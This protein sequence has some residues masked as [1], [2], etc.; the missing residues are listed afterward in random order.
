[1]KCTRKPRKNQIDTIPGATCAPT[2]HVPDNV[3]L[4]HTCYWALTRWLRHRRAT[5]AERR[6]GGRGRSM[7]RP[8]SCKGCVVGRYSA[9][10][11]SFRGAPPRRTFANLLVTRRSFCGAQGSRLL[12]AGRHGHSMVLSAYR[13]RPRVHRHFRVSRV[14]PSSAPAV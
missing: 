1:M 7:I 6:G 10:G 13:S 12:P 5:A 11:R 14:S 3:S 9:G 2:Q 8:N 4:C